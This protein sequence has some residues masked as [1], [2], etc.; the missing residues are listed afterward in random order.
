M[1]QWM[2]LQ[3]KSKHKDLQIARWMLNENQQ[4]MELN[5]GTDANPHMVK[6]NA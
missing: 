4:L 2:K 5:L 6:I 3:Q 1:L